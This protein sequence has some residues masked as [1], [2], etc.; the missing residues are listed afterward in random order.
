MP[1]YDIDVTRDGRFWL[2]RVPAMMG[3]VDSDGSVNV[4]DVTQAR[5]EG[6]IEEMA[7]EFIATVTDCPI[8][9]ISVRRVRG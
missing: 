7:R 6:E 1:T 8:E 5:H 4:S 2:I 9:D 3:Y